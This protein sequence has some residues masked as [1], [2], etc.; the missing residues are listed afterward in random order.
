MKELKDI[1]KKL[2]PILKKYRWCF[3][4]IFIIILLVVFLYCI[5]FRITYAPELETSW[6]AVIAFANWGSV[7]VSLAGVIA[8]FL[9]VWFVIIVP[10]QIA[11][12]QY[13]IDLFEKRLICYNTIQQFLVVSDEIEDRNTKKAIQTAFRIY[14]VNPSDNNITPNSL[15]ILLIQK[16]LIIMSGEFLFNNY[17]TKLLQEI[18]NTAISLVRVSENIKI[19]EENLTKEGM[20][21]KQKYCKLCTKFSN[22][23][24]N[25]IE[26]DL[27]IEFN[28]K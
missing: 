25:D 27:K 13:K 17:N 28:N 26:K 19:Q 7:F 12:R 18:L 9:A 15:M 22:E 21:C 2:T 1:L 6:N 20:V 24:L 11:N 3:V 10:K 4:A 5:G 23:F 14:F 8:S 16:E